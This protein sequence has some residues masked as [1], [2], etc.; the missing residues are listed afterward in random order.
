MVNRKSL[1][2]SIKRLR[3]SIKV[4]N[5]ANRAYIR[6]I[7]LEIAGKTKRRKRKKRRKTQRGGKG[8]RRRRKRAKKT[9]GCM[10]H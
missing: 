1:R 9:C 2:K 8:K 5:N 6:S 10:G 4:Q 7:K 3:K